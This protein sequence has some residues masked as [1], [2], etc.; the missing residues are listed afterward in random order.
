VSAER[1]APRLERAALAPACAALKVFPLPGVV[2]LPGAPAPFH[3]FEPRYLALFE[4]ALEGDRVVAVP[5]VVEPAEAMLARPRLL[6]MAGICFVVGEE[7][8]PDGTRDVL[9]HCAGRV[10][11]LDELEATLPYR[12]FHAELVD[13]V[14]PD[15]G[16]A[17]ALQ[18]DVE[19]LAQLCYDLIALLPA[20][21]GVARLTEALARM[22]D[23]G[24]MADLVA[25]AAITEPE[26]RYRALAEP[27]VA[28]RLKM[29]DGELAALVLLLSQ[30]RGTRN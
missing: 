20:E 25:A 29:V 2:L 17:A 15:A 18:G 21:S 7:R 11:L 8:N 26:A 1:H 27:A 19:A 6:P 12:Q 22:K 5:T 9:L 16:G 24:A 13:D 3:V 28:A 14:Y 30:G 10:R 4:A 23:P